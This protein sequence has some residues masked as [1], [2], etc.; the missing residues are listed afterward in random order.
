[1][2]IVVG[3]IDTAN[4]SYN[5]IPSNNTSEREREREVAPLL[6]VLTF[7]LFFNKRMSNL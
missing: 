6:H 2:N 5:L 1:V 7:V 4:Q 3:G